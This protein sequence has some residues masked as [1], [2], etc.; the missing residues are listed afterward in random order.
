MSTLSISLLENGEIAA[1]SNMMGRMESEKD[2]SDGKLQFRVL[3]IVA[4]ALFCDYL[5]LTLCI[6]ILPNLLDSTFSPFF[7]SLVFAAKPAVQFL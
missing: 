5:L 4:L 1:N 6:P 2:T 3:G 7:I